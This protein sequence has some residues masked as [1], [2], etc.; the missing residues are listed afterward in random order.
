[1]RRAAVRSTKPVVFTLLLLQTAWM[2]AQSGDR[3]GPPAAVDSPS[4]FVLRRLDG[5]VKVD[6]RTWLAVD[7]RMAAGRIDAPNGSFAVTL[8]APS[9][10]GDVVR[11]L[12]TF[13]AGTGRSLSL[14]SEPVSYALVT[15]DSR[16][17][18]TEPLIVIDVQTWRR[19]NLS[20]A[21]GL[22]PYIVPHAMSADGRRLVFWRRPCA[23]DC[24][25]LP[26]EH[27]EL[28]FPQVPI[29]DAFPIVAGAGYEGAII[30][31][32][33]LWHESYRM[34]ITTPALPAWTPGVADI[35]TAERHLAAFFK[36]AMGEP[37]KAASLG[38]SSQNVISHL[39]VV[40]KTQ[41]LT[42]HNYGATVKG[43]Q[44]ML[45][46]AGVGGGDR[47]RSEPV[48]MFDNGCGDLW[49]EVSLKAGVVRFSCGGFAAPLFG[50]MSAGGYNHE[51]DG[52]RGLCVG[53]GGSDGPGLSAAGTAADTAAD[54]A[55]DYLRSLLQFA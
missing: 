6:G 14:G 47:W 38:N 22:E 26:T 55:E 36:L 37:A 17:I 8:S 20:K 4:G 10:A 28:A 53:A 39:P 30:P 2:A 23:V 27:F 9:E 12:A 45:V 48:V 21:F 19:Y 33:S 43:Q 44:Q 40:L 24:A 41:T 49:L 18:L 16:W 51:K 25:S 3:T 42:R 7:P 32:T 54:T 29:A 15:P 35:A 1:M 5:P 31:A 13:S 34:G 46:H 50:K 11:F 52:R